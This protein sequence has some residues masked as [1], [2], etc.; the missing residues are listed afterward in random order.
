MSEAKAIAWYAH[1]YAVWV[2]GALVLVGVGWMLALLPRWARALWSRLR[3]EAYVPWE[4]LRRSLGLAGA[5]T[6]V[7]LGSATLAVERG[8][9]D[10]QSYTQPTLAGRLELRMSREAIQASWS[11]P[12]GSW[13]QSWQ[14]GCSRLSLEGEFVDWHRTARLLGL[15]NRHRLAGGRL[16]CPGIRAPSAGAVTARFRPPSPTW[17]A[18]RRWDRWVP[19][20][21]V[22]RR[23]SPALH[24]EEGSWRVFVT[25]GG[26][27]LA[28]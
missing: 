22:E 5:G 14:M 11:E 17:E 13:V 1:G 26:Y 21:R 15:R 20:M 3:G 18:L 10:F 8:L 6:L 16:S 25:P 4:L 2:G 27:A 23:N 7:I 19:V 9:G 24:V 28:E 12:G